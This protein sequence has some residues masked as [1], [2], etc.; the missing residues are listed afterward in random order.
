[1]RCTCNFQCP[2]SRAQK[3]VCGS[4]GRLYDHECGLRE[5]AC[6]QQAPL[7]AMPCPGGCVAVAAI[8][9]CVDSAH[10]CCPDGKTMAHGPNFAGCPSK[11]GSYSATCDPVSG[12]CVCKPGVGGLRCDRCEPGFWG[13]HKI[14]EGNNGCAPVSPGKCRAEQSVRDDCEQMTGRCVCKHGIQG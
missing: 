14:A 11:L 1:M 7:N 6:R 2:R 12:Q 13:L 9:E 8:K 4:D 10:G 5:E 3:P